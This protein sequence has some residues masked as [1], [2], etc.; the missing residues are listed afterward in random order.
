MQNKLN[1]KQFVEEK[2]PILLILFVYLIFKIMFLNAGMFWDSITILSKP[3]TFLFDQGIFNF[4]YPSEY[5]NG[6]PQLVPFYIAL[7]WTFFGRTLLIT[8]LAFLPI[9][10]LILWQLYRLSSKLF[11]TKYAP[12]VF[13]L[14]AIDPTIMSLTLGLYQDTFLILFSILFINALLEKNRT[15][16]MIFMLLLCMVSRRGMLL[17]FGFMLANYINMIFLEK[18]TFWE[19]LKQI[20]SSYLPA[21]IFVFLFV[22]WRLWLYGWFFTT[23]QTNTGELVSI[24]GIA[25]N[26]LILIRWFFD[27]GRIFLWIFF[28]YFIIKLK[29]K[30]IFFKQNSLIVLLFF[31]LLIVM[32]S[33]TLPLANPF[34][35]RYFVVIYSLFAIFFSKL[36]ISTVSE[37][38]G[39]RIL[40]L[41]AT[42]LFC[43]NFWLYPEKL[44]QSWDASLAHLPY[45]ELRKQTID[46][47]QK[48]YIDFQTVGVGFP[49]YAQ[50]SYI[51][52]N[53]DNKKFGNIDFKKNKWI[54]YSNI[55]NF[56]DQEIEQTKRW[57][58]IK[59]FQQGTVFMKIY[60]NPKYQDVP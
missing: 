1:V 5:D 21:A 12:Y 23:N 46:Y 18:K 3:A 41:A 27:D 13:I 19:T 58:L 25:R 45:F 33:V 37:K 35:A 55:F 15:G 8:H 38:S 30:T 53:N 16:M 40:L 56:T 10:I 36:I 9:S 7:V 51:D 34:G 29:N 6:D 26:L 59:E 31:V 42:L 52:I 48:N 50:F 14:L 20:F 17:T 54:V 43:G 60:K 4:H 39:K 2:F 11:S 49:M 22:A 57:M 32:M 28:A 47:L 44:S 24:S